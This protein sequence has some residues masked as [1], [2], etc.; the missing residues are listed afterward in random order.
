M[1]LSG[2]HSAA[3]LKAL[4]GRLPPPRRAI[5][6]ELRDP[7]AALEQESPP[8]DRALLLWL[9]GP[10]SATGEDQAEL[11]LH[12]GRAVVAA[13]LA[14]LARLPGLRPA[15]AGEFTRRA[16]ANGRLDLAEAEG[17]ADLLAAET[18]S[19][20]R[21]A[22]ALASGEGSRRIAGWQDTI[23]GIA[24]R[25]EAA[26]NF[27]DEGDVGEDDAMAHA[28]AQGM[29]RLAATLDDEL[30]RPRAEIIAD[31]L[32]VVIAGPPNSGKSTLINALAQREVAIVS[33]IAGTT[34][35][36]VEVPLALDGIAMRF[37]DTAGLR[38][39]GADPI[40]AI[41]IARARA[42][43]ERADMLLW[44]GEAGSAPAHPHRLVIAAQADRRR[45]EPGWDDH[46]AAADLLLSAHS[47][48]GM[49]ALHAALVAMARRLIPREGEVAWRER[50][51]DALRDARD[52]LTIDPATR[53]GSD[54]ILL[55]ERLR[56]A[57]AALGRITGHS[58]VDAMLD[59]LFGRFCIG[60]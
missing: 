60:K 3:A 57:D 55:A 59:A 9:P 1:R 51:R 12:G 31:G 6:A 41:G 32:A 48:E 23:H 8:L 24:A 43:A 50:Q 37:S 22:M 27:S 33:P 35:D 11:H 39:E 44:L 34:R 56:W 54:L 52:A 16:F 13:V 49:D 14:A 40:E 18:E 20:R 4:A 7:D 53:E 58:G 17:L 30:A 46:A 19:Q 10:A 5:L 42:A 2:P 28:I 38:G 15:Q 36:I 21:Q 29:A 47:G 45:D 26:L 25:A